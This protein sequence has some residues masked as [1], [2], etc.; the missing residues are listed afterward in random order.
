MDE[1][2][3]GEREPAKS[4]PA[5]EGPSTGDKTPANADNR[6]KYDR[7][8]V[9]LIVVSCVALPLLASTITLAVVGDFS[10]HR[11]NDGYKRNSHG[12][13]GEGPMP[14]REQPLPHHESPNERGRPYEQNP[15]RIPPWA[16]P[17]TPPELPFLP[18]EEREMPPD[19][20]PESPY[21]YPPATP[22]GNGL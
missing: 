13:T 8:L 11:D 15:E 2:A 3:S 1:N 17:E 18:P 16:L 21:Q 10:C 22:P 19:Y 6:K 20:T 12:R 5:G 14:R 7:T 4:A 9:A